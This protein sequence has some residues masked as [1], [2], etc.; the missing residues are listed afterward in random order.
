[1]ID[2]NTMEIRPR[3]LALQAPSDARRRFGDFLLRHD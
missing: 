1:V 2:A 3:D